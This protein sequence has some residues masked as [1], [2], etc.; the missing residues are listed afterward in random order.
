LEHPANRV[1]FNQFDNADTAY[2]RELLSVLSNNFKWDSSTTNGELE[3][4]RD[5]GETVACTLILMSEWETK[6]PDYLSP[7]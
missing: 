7:D 1:Q 5:T 2:K 3:L 4:I 6:L